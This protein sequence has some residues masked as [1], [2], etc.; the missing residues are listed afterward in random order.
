MKKD[1]TTYYMILKA[2]S[3]TLDKKPLNNR[4]LWYSE[5]FMDH[6]GPVPRIEDVQF[7]GKEKLPSL[8]EIKFHVVGP[9]QKS[10]LE[11]ETE[12]RADTRRKV[13]LAFLHVSIREAVIEVG[14]TRQR[15]F[16]SLYPLDPEIEKTL[17]RIR[18][19]KNMFIE[20]TSDRIHSIAETDNLSSMGKRRALPHSWAPRRQ[21]RS[22]DREKPTGTKA[23]TD[24]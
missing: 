6:V 18:K 17:N 14:M 8:F 19:T 23:L 10:Q 22:A 2:R 16:G 1:Y 5:W 9:N 7:L 21:V 24:R 4:V 20:H 3:S 13:I 12:S 11:I 15:S